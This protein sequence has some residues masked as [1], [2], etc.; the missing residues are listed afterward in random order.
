VLGQ[1]INNGWKAVATPGPGAPAGAHPVTLGRPELIDSF[2]NGWPVTQADLAALGGSSFT[3]ELTWTPQ[4]RV[5]VALLL[6]GATLLLCL[7]LGFLPER[8]RQRLRSRLRPWMLG[9]PAPATVSADA[10]ALELSLRP[11]P[12]TDRLPT[13]ARALV[14]GLVTGLV[15]SAVTSL[16]V[17][18]LVAVLVVAGLRIPVLRWVT[19][20]G[21]LAFIVAG[22]LSVITGQA[23]H[24]YLPGSNWA[25]SFV[26]SG[27][28]VWIG[29]VLLLADAIV[30]SAGLRTPAPKPPANAEPSPPR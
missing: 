10:P 20:L 11:A 18:L 17:G 25:G 28:M 16:G 13:R 5:W 4:S 1:S 15:A 27:K 22:G 21:A 24:H 23:A 30:V 3:V 8:W 6:S 26:S 29:V 19:R 12:R 9:R 2:A 7:V 14:L